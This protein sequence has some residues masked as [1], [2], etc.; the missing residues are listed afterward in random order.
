MKIIE[1]HTQIQ[2]LNGHCLFVSDAHFRT[3]QDAPSAQREEMLIQLIQNAGSL[4]HLFLLGDIFDFWFEYRDVAPKGYVR[5]FAFLKEL[6]QQGVQIHYFIGNHDM[7]VEDYFTELFGAKV[8]AEPQLMNI[9]GRRCL[10]GH[11]D[12]LG[13]KQRKYMLIKR[14]FRFRPN[15]VLYS[16]LH[17]RTAFSIA[18][19]FSQRSRESH[20]EATFQFQG[21]QEYQVMYAREVLTTT[22][23]DFFI[24]AHRHV[25]M[26][27]ELTPSCT[28][29]NVGDWLSHFSYLTFSSENQEPILHYDSLNNNYSPHLEKMSFR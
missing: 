12:G 17:P 4:Q 3:P 1:E 6:S 16:M 22:N 27:Y 23:I 8:Y 14:I 18:R 9:N 20:D 5:L 24:F 19:F 25:P 13:G 15:Q 21:E 10:I 29:Y 2:E 7:W 26:R 11:G 28:F